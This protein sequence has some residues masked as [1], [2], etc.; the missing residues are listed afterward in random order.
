V[1]RPGRLRALAPLA[2][3]LVPIVLLAGAGAIWAW[4]PCGT[5]SCTRPLA[6]VWLL[7]L[8]A[9]PTSVLVGL[10]W[11]AGPVTL[12]AAGTSSVVLWLALGRWAA[13]R[14]TRDVDA[15]WRDVWLELC[16]SV[17]GLWAGVIAGLGAVAFVLI[18]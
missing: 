5:S 7:A 6:V 13:V 14:A 4:W 18:R 2:A 11:T 1:A 9:V 12:A 16:W 17:A 8:L 10:P 3:L 15:T